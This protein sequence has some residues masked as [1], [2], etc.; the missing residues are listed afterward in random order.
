M[1]IGEVWRFVGHGVYSVFNRPVGNEY[2]DEFK[3][4][5]LQP[6][7]CFTV[8]ESGCSLREYIITILINNQKWYLEVARSSVPNLFQKL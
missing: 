4:Y 3:V 6:N 8:V 5:D 1:N 2:D 7:D